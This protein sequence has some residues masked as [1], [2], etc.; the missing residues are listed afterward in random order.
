M[1]DHDDVSDAL[2]PLAGRSTAAELAGLTSDINAM[3]A[4]FWAVRDHPM[5]TTS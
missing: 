2:R 1:T 3:V 5:S 4:E